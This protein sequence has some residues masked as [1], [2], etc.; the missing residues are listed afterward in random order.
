MYVYQNCV[1]VYIATYAVAFKNL[2]IRFYVIFILCKYYLE[3]EMMFISSSA[4]RASIARFK[5]SQRHL[6]AQYDN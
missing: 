2:L 4:L 1:K 6:L 5:S 3:C